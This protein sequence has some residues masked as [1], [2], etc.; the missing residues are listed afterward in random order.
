VLA[1]VA[2]I[3]GLIRWSLAAKASSNPESIVWL[4]SMQDL[5]AEESANDNARKTRV[6]WQDLKIQ[7]AS[8]AEFVHREK[9][10][11]KGISNWRPTE[12]SALG[13]C[14]NNQLKRN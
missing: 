12:K 11:R 5:A 4:G 8:P 13:S 3:T 14:L 9:D 7:S 6:R 1:D 2:L 10:K